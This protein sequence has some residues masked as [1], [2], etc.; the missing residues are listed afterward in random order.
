MGVTESADTDAKVKQ[1]PSEE[2]AAAQPPDRDPS[3]KPAVN[4]DALPVEEPA[5]P[6]PPPQNPATF[7]QKL[8]VAI[9]L[10][11][12]VG[13]LLPGIWLIIDRLNASALA[14]VSV[15]WE[16]PAG[17]T[18]NPGPAAFRYDATAKKLVHYGVITAERKL[19]LRALFAPVSE[20]PAGA[21]PS[22]PADGANSG[23]SPRGVTSATEPAGTA[24]AAADTGPAAVARMET[25]RRAYSEAID[26][27]AYLA[28]ARQGAVIG[29]LLLLGGL[30]GALGAVLRSLVDFVG[31]AS[32]TQQ[33]DMTR[34][35]PLYFT[36]PLVGAILGFVLVVLF[37]AQLLTGG[38]AQPGSDSFWWLGVAV[39]G[40]FSTVDVTLRLRV[41]AKALFGESAK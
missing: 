37:K 29:L 8:G 20:E 23:A 12:W 32:Y 21:E 11:F 7:R 14:E 13:V 34:W 16:M 27:L 28:N 9:Y 2:R 22:R 5:K 4:D 17:V 35:W 24:R 18:L 30:G 25:L 3:R 41:A 19:E 33:L 6:Q 1:A 40:G 15:G 39:L 26:N 38:N 36:R 31:H 10:L